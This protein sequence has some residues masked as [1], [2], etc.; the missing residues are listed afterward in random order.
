VNFVNFKSVRLYTKLFL[1]CLFSFSTIRVKAWDVDF[2]RRQLD[3]QSVSDESRLPAS[4]ES[5][6]KISLVEQLIDFQEL[7][8]DVVILSTAKGFVPDQIRLK[9]N[10]AYKIHIVNVNAS[11]KNTSFVMD[12]FSEFHSTSFGVQKTFVITPKKEG[13]F[14]FNCPETAISGKIVIYD[15]AARRLSSVNGN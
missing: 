15:S 14:S 1:F 11:Q 3:F 6:E 4:V 7:P 8:Q 10:G 5:T 2:S 9:K 13:V 12:A